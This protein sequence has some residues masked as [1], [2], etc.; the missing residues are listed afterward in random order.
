MAKTEL[1]EWLTCK[2]AAKLLRIS[3]NYFYVMSKKSGGPPV[4][5]LGHACV[6]V[7]KDALMRWL[8]TK[9]SNGEKRA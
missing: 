8:E 3:T 1:P 4:I 9:K 6:R 7:S 2:E 5:K